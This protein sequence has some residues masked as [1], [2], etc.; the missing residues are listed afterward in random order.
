VELAGAGA[1]VIVR[2]ND[3]LPHFFL[4]FR[5]VRTVLT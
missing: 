3:S 1:S 4:S 2:W 5:I